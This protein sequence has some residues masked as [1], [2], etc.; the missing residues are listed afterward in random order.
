MDMLLAVVWADD[1]SPADTTDSAGLRAR[2]ADAAEGLPAALR[3]RVSVASAAACGDLGV[4]FDA[5][6]DDARMAATIE[7][8]TASTGR[9][10]DD[11]TVDAVPTGRY[12]MGVPG[13]GV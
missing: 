7:A 6:G 3:A 11:G 1:G 8:M 2:I 4:F 13:A 5:R 9:F 10:L 12:V